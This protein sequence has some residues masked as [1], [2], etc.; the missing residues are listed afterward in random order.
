MPRWPPVWPPARFAGRKLTAD[1]LPAFILRLLG[2]ERRDAYRG[3]DDRDWRRLV[4]QDVQRVPSGVTGRKRAAR[5]WVSGALV[6]GLLILM[7][8]L[9]WLALDTEAAPTAA[10]A[11]R[12]RTDGFLPESFARQAVNPPGAS[13][14]RDVAAIRQSLEAEPQVLSAKVRRLG[15]GL[16][17][18]ELRE[19][20]AVGRIEL[21]QPDGK[22][23][24]R[25]LGA[26]GVPFVGVG[27]P[28]QAVRNLPAVIDLP[29]EALRDGA[30]CA[31]LELA[32][33]FLAAARVGY[34]RLHREWESVSL[35][36]CFDGRAD[37]PGASLRVRVRPSSQ[38]P[39]RPALT[40]IIFSN[41]EWSRELAL[42][43]GL[44]VDELL[45][46]PG[47]NSPAYVL[48]LHIRNRS[49]PGFATL[50]PRLVP[51]SSR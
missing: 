47:M 17:E 46:R 26:D 39:D 34:P 37:I 30:R 28:A 35:R 31:G 5:S 10:A 23:Q 43:A 41:A 7:G 20:L 27:Y 16:I 25:L 11:V 12:F 32:A 8:G 49:Q 38:P 14:S 36:D 18:I 2:L 1:M 15:N 48:K 24:L 6:A 29:P 40:E 4:A 42:L 51:A 9:V 44:G 21:V 13:G 22:P 19:R 3:P 50:E 33:G 45:R